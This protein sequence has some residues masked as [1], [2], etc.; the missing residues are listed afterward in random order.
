[1]RRAAKVTTTLAPAH[2]MHYAYMYYVYVTFAVK[3]IHVESLS[4]LPLSSTSPHTTDHVPSEGC[5][6]MQLENVGSAL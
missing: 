1:M 3:Y 6:I 2:T 4:R 5:A